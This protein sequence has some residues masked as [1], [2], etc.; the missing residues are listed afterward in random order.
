MVLKILNTNLSE[1]SHTTKK[2]KAHVVK[3]DKVVNAV[4]AVAAAEEPPGV[5]SGFLRFRLWGFGLGGICSCMTAYEDML[6]S[7]VVSFLQE[8]TLFKSSLPGA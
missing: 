2:Q 7:L 6:C 3:P 5:D 1:P 8:F 4:S